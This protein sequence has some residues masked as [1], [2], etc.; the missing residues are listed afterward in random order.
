MAKNAGTGVPKSEAGVV[1]PS[2]TGGGKQKS[3]PKT[4][5]SVPARKGKG[6]RAKGNKG[7]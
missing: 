2:K 4:A 6:G 5:R 3:P 1:N 7:V